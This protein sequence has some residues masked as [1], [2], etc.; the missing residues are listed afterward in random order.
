VSEA[1]PAFFELRDVFVN[2]SRETL[3]ETYAT[4]RSSLKVPERFESRP[5]RS[6]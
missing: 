2:H 3:K 1:V 6:S 5:V 4:G